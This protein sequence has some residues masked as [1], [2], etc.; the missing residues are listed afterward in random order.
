MP[1]VLRYVDRNREI[2]ERFIKSF[3]CA[4][5]VSGEA[6]KDKVTGYLVNTLELDIK[7]LQ[8]SML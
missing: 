2:Q 7:L 6:V 1:L 4:S 5:G 3:H 8:R